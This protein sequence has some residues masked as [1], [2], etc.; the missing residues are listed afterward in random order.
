VDRIVAGFNE[1][2][3][4]PDLKAALEKQGLQPMEPMSAGEIATLYATDTE[5]YAKVIRDANIKLSD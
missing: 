2:M 4:A 3:R 1:V 5:K